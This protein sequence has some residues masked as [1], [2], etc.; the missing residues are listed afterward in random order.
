MTATTKIRPVFGALFLALALLLHGAGAASAQTIEDYFLLQEGTVPVV[1][2]FPHGGT[3]SVPSVEARDCSSSSKNCGQDTNTHRMAPAIS[4]AFFALTGHK[5]YLVASYMPRSQVD[6]N[7]PDGSQAYDDI[8]AKPYYDFYHDGVRAYID[9]IRATWGSGVLFDVHGQSAY[10][11]TVVRGTQNG[12][13]VTSLL[14]DKGAIALNGPDSV[15]GVLSSLSYLVHPDLAIPFD[16]QSELSAYRGGYTVRTY[17]SSHAD[18]IDAIQLE[19]GFN[20]RSGSAWEQTSTDL[21]SAARNFHDT[22]LPSS[23]PPEIPALSNT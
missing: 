17:G 5:P 3:T 2:T 14:A 20:F 10:P 16:Q 8:D 11:S 9:A 19:I 6:L 4:D 12:D 21:A 18:G 15:F 23:D 7:R 13:T 22:F 1:F